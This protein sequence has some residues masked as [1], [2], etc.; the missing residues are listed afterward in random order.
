MSS[1]PRVLHVITDLERGGAE[2]VLQRLLARMSPA[3]IT[4]NVVSLAGDGPVGEMILQTGH[5]VSSLDASR[6]SY[7][8]SIPRLA[9]M[10]RDFRPSVVQTWMYHA[11]VI[12]GIAARLAHVPG[13]VWGLHAGPLPR[14]RSFWGIHLRRAALGQLSRSIPDKIVCC[15]ESTFEAH[16][17]AHYSRRR[18]VVIPNGFVIPPDPLP[19]QAEVR[20]LVGIPGDVKVVGRVG[21][22]HEQKGISTLAKAF[23]KLVEEHTDCRLVLVGQGFDEENLELTRLLEELGVLDRTHLLGEQDDPSMLYR[24]FDVAV[25]SSITEAMPLVVGEAMAVA[26]PVVATDAGDSSILI[27]DPSR[28][29]PVRDAD[30][31]ASAVSRVLALSSAGRDQ[32]GR[33]DRDRVSKHFGIEEMASRYVSLYQELSA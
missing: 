7:M 12:G 9:D 31:L 23:R 28:I 27:A 6:G 29:V 4:A 16:V 21:R 30:R 33:R 18:M 10:I 32:L 24:A 11:D 20:A 17:S 8:A 25:S 26:T 15:S 5:A 1:S 22:S 3:D 13:I 19:P 2:I 14:D